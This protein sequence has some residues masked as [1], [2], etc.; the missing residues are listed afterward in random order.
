MFS[1]FLNLRAKEAPARPN[2]M[3]KTPES[4]KNEGGGIVII[5]QC[6]DFLMDIII[7][8]VDLQ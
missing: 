5:S 6:T 7:F 3:G 1:I 8:S 4:V 2:K